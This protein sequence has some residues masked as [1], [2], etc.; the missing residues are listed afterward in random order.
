M[1]YDDMIMV[2]DDMTR[3][4]R[5]VI[6]LMLAASPAAAQTF[7]LKPLMP[8]NN[9]SDLD[10]PATERGNPGLGDPAITGIGAGLQEAASYGAR[11]GLLTAAVTTVAG[12]TGAATI[13]GGDAAVGGAAGTA[14]AGGRGAGCGGGGV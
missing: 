13:G 14:T 10:N 1:V 8:G 5:L 2:Y 12:R 4:G 6:A 9:L 7:S 3:L 11:S